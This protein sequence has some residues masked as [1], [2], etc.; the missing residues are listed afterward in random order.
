M[1]SLKSLS[2]QTNSQSGLDAPGTHLQPRPLVLLE[3]TDRDEHVF[4]THSSAQLHGRQ[5]QRELAGQ[6]GFFQYF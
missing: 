4:A 1:T 6:E 3:A 2:P 5:N